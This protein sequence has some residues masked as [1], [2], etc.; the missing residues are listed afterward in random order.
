MARAY[1]ATA[2]GLCAVAAV[3]ALAFAAPTAIA[4]ETVRDATVVRV[5][6]GDTFEVA[7]GAK[8][9][10]RNFD[11]PELRS[12]ECPEEKRMAQAAR[13]AARRMLQGER[14]RLAVDG[15]DRYRR[16]VADVTL[17]RSGHDFVADMIA[18]GHGARWDYGNEPQPDWCDA[19]RIASAPEVEE[20]ED[21][22]PTLDDVEDAL[23]KASKVARALERLSDALGF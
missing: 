9:R 5:I 10:V 7:G 21:A 3:S 12:Y 1:R 22:G 11:T 19:E 8:V 13:D 16:L 14:V 17:K 4:T 6:D 2:H 20:A 15:E 23:R 18:E